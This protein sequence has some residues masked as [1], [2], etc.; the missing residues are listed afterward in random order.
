M[1]GS[2]S[3]SVIVTAFNVEDF[4]G[5][6]LASVRAQAMPGLEIVVVNDGSTDGTGA[7]LDAMASVDGRLAVVHRANGGVSSARNTG[8]ERSTGEYVLFVDG[9][10]ILLPGACAALRER[11][12]VTSADIVVADF[13]TRTAFDGAERRTSGGE[14]ETMTGHE[15]SRSLLRPDT[16]VAVWNKLVR[17]SLYID[18]GVRFAEGVSMGEDLAVLFEL[19]C[20]AGSVVKLERPVIVY[21]MRPGSLISTLSPHLFSVTVALERVETLIDRYMAADTAVRRDFEQACYYHVMCTRVIPGRVAG[22]VHRALW[23]WYAGRRRDGAHNPSAGMRLSR[24]ER[25]VAFAYRFSYGAGVVVRR[26]LDN[27]RRLRPH[28]GRARDG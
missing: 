18:H 21:L 22:G 14:F 28:L 12:E 24:A 9:D 5:A 19:G 1:N 23:Q 8:L 2:A 15:F 17:R 27:L 7:L 25:S 13:V 16:P 6:T 20:V 4:I 11:A 26:A 10:D 3:I